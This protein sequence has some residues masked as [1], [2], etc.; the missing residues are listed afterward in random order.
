MRFL[1]ALGITLTLMSQSAL[2]GDNEDGLRS[3]QSGD[4]AN[5]LASFRRAALQGNPTAQYNLALMYDK[6]Q[7]VPRDYKEAAAWYSKA[8]AHGLGEAQF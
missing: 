4:H 8:A 6:G 3:L 7:G 1:A 5:A 2:S